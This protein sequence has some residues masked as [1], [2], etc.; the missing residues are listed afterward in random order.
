MASSKANHM[1]TRRSTAQPSFS[2]T[3]RTLSSEPAEHSLGPDVH[4]LTYEER[5]LLWNARHIQSML[6]LVYRPR[7]RGR[8]A[9]EQ[10][11]R[12]GWHE[13]ISTWFGAVQELGNRLVAEQRHARQAQLEAWRLAEL[14]VEEADQANDSGPAPE[15]PR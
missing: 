4:E 2:S 1:T 12:L 11:S 7:G 3:S 13:E 10:D 6:D 15:S 14:K 9:D 8:D 5:H